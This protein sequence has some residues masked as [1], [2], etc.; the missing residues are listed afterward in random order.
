MFWIV[1]SWIYGPFLKNCSLDCKSGASVFLILPVAYCPKS[2]FF[3]YGAILYHSRNCSYFNPSGL[4]Y[5]AVAGI[6]KAWN[7][8]V[9]ASSQVYSGWGTTYS[10]LSFR[11]IGCCRRYVFK[12][13]QFECF[14]SRRIGRKYIGNYPLCFLFIYIA[15]IVSCLSLCATER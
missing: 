9:A 3:C 12:P 14:G 10:A 8:G 11:R 7:N 6:Q 2:G 1:S 13:Y 5:V 4:C 15:N